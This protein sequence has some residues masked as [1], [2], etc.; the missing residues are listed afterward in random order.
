MSETQ[1]IAKVKSTVNAGHLT[2]V[3]EAL[4]DVRDEGKLKFT[5]DGIFAKVNDPSNTMMAVCK[6]SSSA[7]NGINIE[8]GDE[9]HLASRYENMY[10]TLSSF[11]KSTEIQVEYPH[12]VSG[13]HAVRFN[14][15]DE[16]MEYKV[17]VLDEDTVADMPQASPLSHK[18]RIVVSGS[19]LKK[20]I[21]NAERFVSDEENSVELGTDD[22]KFYVKSS[23]KIDGSFNK[24][25]YQSGPSDGDDLGNVASKIGYPK[26][27]DVKS[28]IGSSNNVTV[29]IADSKPVRFDVDLDESGEAQIIYIIAPRIES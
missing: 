4:K 6:L 22:D 10:D 3:F 12:K 5:N 28:V 20:A 7:L 2:N 27:D 1:E 25:F 17:T 18:R 13:S 24:E 11:G 8:G 16:G 29:H 26:L 14:A 21:N 15:P 23:D 19:D 9:V